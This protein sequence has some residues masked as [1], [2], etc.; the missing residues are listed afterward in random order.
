MGRISS[1]PR[2]TGTEDGPLLGG[3]RTFRQRF[4]A[5]VHEYKPYEQAA[6]TG[7]GVQPLPPLGACV[8]QGLSRNVIWLSQ[9]KTVRLN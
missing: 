8:L 3:K 5:P 7:L 6:R 9:V 4:N 1:S 2:H